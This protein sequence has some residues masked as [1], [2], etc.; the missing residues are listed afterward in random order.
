MAV[1]SSPGYF[2]SELYKHV[3]EIKFMND[4]KTKS[5]DERTRLIKKFVKVDGQLDKLETT[6]ENTKKV[7]TCYVCRSRYFNHSK[8]TRNKTTTND[9]TTAGDAVV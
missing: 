3:N 7:K 6:G 2:N 9:A 4:F 1:E 8:K 5:K